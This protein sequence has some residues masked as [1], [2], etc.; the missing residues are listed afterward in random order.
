MA[1]PVQ[2][3]DL[4][5]MGRVGV[6]L[7]ALQS[8]APLT[9]VKTVGEFQGGSASNVTAVDF[10]PI[11]TAL[12]APATPQDPVNPPG[13]R[14]GAPGS[15]HFVPAQA[16]ARPGVVRKHSVPGHV[17]RPRSTRPARPAD[18]R[19]PLPTAPEKP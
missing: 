4:I 8:R 7:Y 19:L 9:R 3:Y 6:D 2:P 14:S 11:P 17:F 5:T 13:R 16:A 1:E 12:S 18:P 15:R 10:R